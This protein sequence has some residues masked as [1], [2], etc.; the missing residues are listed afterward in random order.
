MKIK[1]VIQ[2]FGDEKCKNDQVEM[3]NRVLDSYEKICV[4]EDG[5]M[6]DDSK[7]GG[8]IS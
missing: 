1:L 3:D 4:F 7:D 6:Q 5:E 8:S 2:G